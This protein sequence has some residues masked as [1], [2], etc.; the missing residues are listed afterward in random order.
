[1]LVRFDVV[2]R[3]DGEYTVTL[4]VGDEKGDRE[5]TF[6][7]LTEYEFKRAVKSMKKV[8]KLIRN[9]CLLESLGVC[10]KQEGR[11]REGP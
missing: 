8:R 7:P 9:R 3:D 10:G 4:L 6:V 5:F 1:M 2:T 11:A